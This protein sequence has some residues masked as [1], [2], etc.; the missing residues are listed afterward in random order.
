[1]Q[2]ASSSRKRA[3]RHARHLLITLFFGSILPVQA[4]DTNAYPDRPITI[5][6]GSAPG[7]IDTLARMLTDSLTASLGQPV[8]VVNKPG[9]NGLL[10]VEE[11]RH[12]KPDGYNI[13]FAPTSH[14]VINPLV[15]KMATYDAIRDFEPIGHHAFMPMVWIANKDAGLHELQDVVQRAKEKPAGLFMGNH[16]A[17]G[18][19]AIMEMLFAKTHDLD[20]VLVPHPSAPQ[21]IMR[22]I[23]GDVQVSVETLS[24]IMPRIKG[25]QVTP[26]AVTGA[27]RVKSLPKVP[28]WLEAGIPDKYAIQF[29][30]GF[31]AP[32]DTPRPIVDKLNAAIN[33]AVQQPKVKNMMEDLG[34]NIVPLS[35]QEFRDQVMKDKNLFRELAHTIGLERQ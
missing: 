18:A 10:G 12:A 27:S 7:G 13:L 34:G 20:V 23:A 1:M 25:N 14:M 29:W 19:A 22:L 11:V 31:F 16:G 26:L 8:I 5:T 30:Y 15:Y 3:I 24:T 4:T 2:I 6:T 28:S 35:A 21:S 32:K 33:D 9:A 17:G